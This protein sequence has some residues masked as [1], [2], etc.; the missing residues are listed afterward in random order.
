V[1]T[2]QQARPGA[3][4]REGPILVGVG[5]EFSTDDALGVLVAREI[6]RRLPTGLRVVEA[7]GEGASLLEIWKGAPGV[8]I[9]DA[10]NGPMPGDIHRFDVSATRIPKS[11][12]LFSSH[13]FGVAE[14]IEM[15]RELHELPPVAILYG[16]E[17]EAFEPGVG[18]SDSVL[19]SLLQLLGM[20]EQDLC[21][22]KRS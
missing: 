1:E 20:I 16:I 2:E 11:L 19:R 9:V 13:A 3:A 10:I 7:S 14:A 5:N 17:G 22:F 15:A 6:R 12:S 4:E 8:I 18:L 21:K